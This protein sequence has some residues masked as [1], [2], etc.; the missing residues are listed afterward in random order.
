VEGRPA[1]ELAAGDTLVMPSG[2]R[3]TWDVREP[4]RKLYVIVDDAAPGSQR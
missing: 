4:L 3:G 2:W 1:V